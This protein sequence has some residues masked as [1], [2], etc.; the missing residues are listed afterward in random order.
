MLLACKRNGLVTWAGYIIGFPGDT[1]ESVL[2]DVETLKRELPIDL[3]EFFFLTP[4]P[5]S[6]DHQR[7]ASAGVPMDDDLNKYDL[8]HAVTGHPRMSKAEWEE[9]YRLAWQSYYTKEHCETIMRRAAASGV[10]PNRMYVTLAYFHHA[11]A[12]E[13]VHPLE[14][15]IFRRKFRR[16]RRSGVAPRFP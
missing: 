4:L 1:R 10:H 13:G 3:L 8:N 9:M 15:G 6:V 2:R 12:V 11:V 7:L 14:G 16:D 5:G